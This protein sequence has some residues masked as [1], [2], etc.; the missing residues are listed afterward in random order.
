[1]PNSDWEVTSPDFGNVSWTQNTAAFNSGTASAF[2]ENYSADSADVDELIGPTI[3]IQAISNPVFTFKLAFRQKTSSDNDAL[4]IWTS[5]DCG[6]NWSLR[7]TISG[8]SLATATPASTTYFIPTATQWR[9][10]T[11]SI[12]NLL[13]S[14]N[15]RI[16]FQLI[17]GAGNNLYIDD[18]NIIGN[19][20]LIEN[21]NAALR[22]S[23]VPN[24][25]TG[26]SILRY[27]LTKKEDLSYE[28]ID[29][30]GNSI[31]H[32]NWNDLSS[33]L[34]TQKIAE[35]ISLPAGLYFVRLSSEGK[36]SVQKLVIHY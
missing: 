15:A 28:L 12:A 10:E 34:Y 19:T 27:E 2:I 30:L 16:K 8:A 6:R 22:F 18:I 32:F 5:N 9:Q 26:N 21:T 1:L 29:V 13:S 14:T 35:N 4:K 24:P 17:S 3:N 11:V 33:G 31:E 7:K 36:T 23:I 25:S 20:G